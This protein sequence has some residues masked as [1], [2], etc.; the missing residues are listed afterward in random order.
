MSSVF[1]LITLSYVYATNDIN[2][3]TNNGVIHKTQNP[4]FLGF[5]CTFASRNCIFSQE[6]ISETGSGNFASVG[7]QNIPDQIKLYAA[8]GG[9]SRRRYFEVTKS[10][11]RATVPCP[12]VGGAN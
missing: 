7:E 9:I 1:L 8:L 4:N 11:L 6:K 12:P 10:H 2:L 5:C 3:V